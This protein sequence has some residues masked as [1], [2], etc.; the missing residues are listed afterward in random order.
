MFRRSRLTKHGKMDFGFGLLKELGSA[1]TPC[2]TPYILN[3]KP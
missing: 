3:P 1:A 2:A